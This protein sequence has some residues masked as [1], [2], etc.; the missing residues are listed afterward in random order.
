MKSIPVNVMSDKPLKV[1]IKLVTPL[2]IVGLVSLLA[3][4]ADQKIK[5]EKC[6]EIFKITGFTSVL[7]SLF[8][9]FCGNVATAAWMKYSD[10]IIDDHEDK[11]K[12]FVN[13]IYSA[14]IFQFVLT[15]AAICFADN[16]LQILNVPNEWYGIT[17]EYFVVLT[18]SSLFTSVCGY[19]IC[20]INGIGSVTEIFIVKNVKCKEDFFN[21]NQ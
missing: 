17:K 1:I 10:R 4:V 8:T 13:S 2:L 7:V 15:V 3:T 14:L 5:A 12:Y 19:Y 9:N 6:V 21:K 20:I 11:N 16:I 18:A